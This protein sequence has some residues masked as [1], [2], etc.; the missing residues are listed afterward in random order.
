MVRTFKDFKELAIQDALSL[1]IFS[2]AGPGD[3]SLKWAIRCK[4]TIK[5]SFICDLIRIFV[6]VLWQNGHK[7][8]DIYSSIDELTEA[9]K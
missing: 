2:V 6:T 5:D 1:I 9:L 4:K 7:T 3:L 8:K